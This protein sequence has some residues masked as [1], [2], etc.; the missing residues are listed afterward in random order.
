MRTKD[1]CSMLKKESQQDDKLSE[2]AKK[3]QQQNIK[4]MIKYSYEL[5][6]IG[7]IDSLRQNIASELMED[8]ELNQEIF[9]I[10]SIL[11][12]YLYHFWKLSEMGL[13]KEKKEVELKTRKENF[14]KWLQ[15]LFSGDY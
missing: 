8:K 12:Q 9:S 11:Q 3:A 7:L 1:I 13:D 5:K 14:E 2:F 10:I 4:G 15:N 6:K